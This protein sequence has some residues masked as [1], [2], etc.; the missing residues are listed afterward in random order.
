MI[1]ISIPKMLIQGQHADVLKMTE[2]TLIWFLRKCKTYQGKTHAPEKKFQAAFDTPERRARSQSRLA[3]L[4][5]PLHRKQ[6]V[7]N[8]SCD[9][10]TICAPFSHMLNYNRRSV[11][12]VQAL[13]C[14]QHVTLQLPADFGFFFGVFVVEIVFRPHSMALV[15]FYLCRPPFLGGFAARCCLLQ[16]FPV[17]RAVFNVSWMLSLPCR[18]RR[19]DGRRVCEGRQVTATRG[20]HMCFF[21]ARIMIG[22]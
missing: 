13:A 1:T 3:C 17:S 4:I 2:T 10:C 15:G 6:D 20:L 19:V 11:R 12:V 9:S 5:W 7:L 16:V 21:L 14:E 8:V 18:L 22:K